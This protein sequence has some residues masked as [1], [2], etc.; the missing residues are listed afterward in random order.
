M[1]FV[2]PARGA[3]IE[4]THVTQLTGLLRG[5]ESK[6]QLVRLYRIE[7]TDDYANI[8]GNVDTTNGLA[9]KIQYGAVASP[10]T[11]ATFAKA[12][13]TLQSADATRSLVISNSG[14]AITAPSASFSVN[15]QTFNR[16]VAVYNVLD[17]GIV[18]GTTSTNAAANTA[19]LEA[20]WTTV[21]T[22]TTGV[23]YFPPGTYP[24]NATALTASTGG[25]GVSVSIEG[26]G[27]NSTVLEFYNTSG[28]SLQFAPSAGTIQRWHMRGLLIQ[29]DGESTGACMSFS[30]SISKVNLVDIEIAS[31]GWLTGIST[32]HATE[33]IVERCKINTRTDYADLVTAGLTP[34]AFDVVNSS[35]MGGLYFHHTELGTI[36]KGSNPASRGIIL[37]FNNSGAVDTVV[38]GE[39]CHL[40]GGDIG[41]LKN[42]GAGNV[43]N[44]LIGAAF[45]TD[46][47]VNV[48]CEP[49]A[50]STT[51]NWQFVGTWMAAYEQNVVVTESNGGTALHF[52][53]ASCYLTDATV[54]AVNFGPGVDGVALSNLQI[55]SSVNT[56]GAS[57][58]TI[59]DNSTASRD[60]SIIGGI[61]QVGSSAAASYSIGS[62]V[63]GVTVAYVTSRGVTGAFG[64]ATDASRVHLA[65]AFLA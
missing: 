50:S 58:L 17:H 7:D 35:T 54:S 16:G 15:G 6:G 61:I 5:D 33:M 40:I 12:A 45:I 4:H 44:V 8:F 56:G 64:G 3:I 24:F 18:T 10:T 21:V 23:I 13:I 14:V 42:S 62:A 36:Q 37:R 63:D 20:L 52:G 31:A 22:A 27:R 11:L 59:G 39:G 41:I 30:S 38:I 1:S 49:P 25:I 9:V 65:G 55:Y 19:A 34:V 51:E 32:A 53:M 60:I 2:D 47:D 26:S 29:N 46:V 43:S 57:A 28:T 48:Q